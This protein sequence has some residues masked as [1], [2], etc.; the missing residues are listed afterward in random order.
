MSIHSNSDAANATFYYTQ[1]DHV[2]LVTYTGFRS[3]KEGKQQRR[4][5]VALTVRY[6]RDREWK[7]IQAYE[8]R[9]DTVFAL[10]KLYN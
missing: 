1:Y 4:Y 7:V 8:S 9:V 6:N 3:G 10:R 5:G 2:G